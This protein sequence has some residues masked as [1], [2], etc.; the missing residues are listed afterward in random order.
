MVVR[1]C[2]PS[3]TSVCERSITPIH[4]SPR[5]CRSYPEA[6]SKRAVELDNGPK[7]NIACED[8]VWCAESCAALISPRADPRIFPKGMWRDW[9]FPD[10]VQARR[11]GLRTP[12]HAAHDRVIG[13][14]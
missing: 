9:A 7:A 10:A 2:W 3:T 11:A 5:H 4:R 6:H 12:V 1:R 8:R 14:P 13:I